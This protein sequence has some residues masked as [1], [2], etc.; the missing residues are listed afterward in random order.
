M[1]GISY[2]QL[3]PPFDDEEEAEEEEEDTIEEEAEEEEEAC[4]DYDSTENTIAINC[5]ASFLDVVETINDPEI[6]EQEEEQEGQ[7]ILN[8]NLE[9]ADDV[10]FAMD[11]NEDGLSY[12]KIT[13]ANGI[14]VHGRIEISGIIIT[15]WDTQTNSPVSQTEMG[16]VPRAFINLRVSEG[17][18]VHDSEIAHLGYQEFGRR[19]FDLFGEGPSHDLEI[20]GSK[21]H[22]MWFAFYS[23]GAYNIVVDGNEY[24]NN[25]KYALD[26]HSGTHD[27]R[28]TNNYLHHNPIGAICSDRCYNILIEGNLVEYNTDHGIFF[29]RNMYDSIA[30]NNHISNTPSGIT[31]SESPNNQI[32]NNT[33]EGATRSGIRLFNPPVPD[34]GLTEGNIVYNNVISNSEDGISAARSHDNILENNMFSN[35]QSNEY[36]LSGDSSIII[37]G[38]QFDNALIAQEGSASSNLVEIVDSEIIEV[39]EGETEGEEEGEGEGDLYNTDS[40]PYRRILSDGD[41]ITVNSS[42]S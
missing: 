31:V 5:D 6:L 33:I 39:T 14:I 42:S 29:S 13:G 19:G 26:P 15:S 37:R 4:I 21:F 18:F 9:V 8:A 24:Y 22:N 40:E 38:Q 1:T 41:S 34:D 11:S 12:L 27:M 30:R 20:R 25:I 17:G 35:I 3:P 28:I 10:T 23:R 2:Q 7:Y 16:S 36:S 32:Y